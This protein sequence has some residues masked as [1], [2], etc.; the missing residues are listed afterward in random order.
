MTM[1]ATACDKAPSSRQPTAEAIPGPSSAESFLKAHWQRP[2]D[3]RGIAALSPS[4]DEKTLDPA[5]CGACHATQFADWNNSLHSKAM[6]PGV[7]GQLVTMVA[8]DPDAA[9][10]CIR[11][12]AP[13]AEQ[14]ASLADV[15]RRAS[16]VDQ[17]VGPGL[18]E[19]G[20]MCAG[21]H[22]RAGQVFGPLR[23]DGSGPAPGEQATPLHSWSAHTAYEDSRFC[24]SCHQFEPDDYALN[25]KLLENTYEEWK[26]SRY[27]NEGVTCQNC[28]MPDRKHL[29][30]GIHDPDMVRRGVTIEVK[31]SS[32]SAAELQATMRVVN[33]GTGHQFP[34]YVTPKVFAEAFQE[35]RQGKPVPGTLQRYVIA[36]E[37]TPEL[38][39]EIADTRLAP[40]AHIDFDYKAA[41]RPGAVALSFRLRVEPDAFYRNLYRSLLDSDSA[42][43]GKSMIHTAWR[44]ASES[45]FI[46]FSQ[47]LALPETSGR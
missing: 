24:A 19:H 15:A 43:A 5:S 44:T 10:S 31:P 38:D 45:G 14:A 29:W 17:R 22:M 33:T 46:A 11:C 12:H 7:V 32:L 36:R 30:R 2:S 8:A 3:G 42:G 27:A 25:G 28:H 37:V 21:C 4:Q 16:S 41:R 6:G 20:V 1:L 23:R 34:T 35:D 9:E 40:G 47:R 13:L 26:A 18:H 39:R